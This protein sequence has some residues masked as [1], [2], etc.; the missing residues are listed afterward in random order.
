MFLWRTKLDGSGHP[1]RLT[2]AGGARHA[3][4]RHRPRRALGDSHLLDVRHAAGDGSGPAAESRGRANVGIERRRLGAHRVA[5]AR[6]RRVLAD[7]H[8]RRRE[9]RFVDDE[10][11]RLR[12]DEEVPGAVLRVRRARVANR[13][14]RVRRQHVPVAPDAHAA[15]LHRGER[16]QPRHAGPAR[17]RV[18]QGRA[19][20]D[21]I[22]PRARAVGRREGRRPD[23]VRRLDAPRGVG[24]ER[25]RVV[26]AAPHVPR[27]RRLSRRDG[28]RARGQ[29]PQLRHHLS[30]ALRRPAQHRRARRTT[31]RHRSTMPTACAAICSSSTARATT[32]CT[33]RAPS[34]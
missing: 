4:V 16:R 17:T 9:A 13:A 3:L 32:T 6:E 18:A 1:E 34:S 7:R 22:A 30:G 21:R 15:R 25:R 20:P 10:A 23:A 28:G 27:A 29:R 19:Q 11:R 8:R 5:A 12:F 33:T 31:T 2:P 24:L 14:R 26:D